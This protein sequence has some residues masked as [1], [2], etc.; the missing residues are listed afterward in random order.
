VHAVRGLWDRLGIGEAIAA[1]LGTK[2]AGEAYRTALVAMALQRLDRP[3]SKLA[4]FDRELEPSWLPEARALKLGQ[5]Y[6]ALDVLAEHGDAI[7]AELFWRSL[8]LFPNRR[9]SR[10]LRRD[11]RLVRDRRRG[12]RDARM[13]RAHLRPA[14][15]ARPCHG[16]P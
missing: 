14:A 8:D 10:L 16:G 2:P 9:R 11:H 5:F 1:R 6:R 7:D 12:R 3:G 15:Q 13:T 4:G